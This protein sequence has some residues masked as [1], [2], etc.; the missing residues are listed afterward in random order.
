MSLTM[1]IA[2]G[3]QSLQDCVHRWATQAVAVAANTFASMPR[4]SFPLHAIVCPAPAF[5]VVQ[6]RRF[7]NT[8]AGAQKVFDPDRAQAGG[9]YHFPVRCANNVI[10]LTACHVVCIIFHSG[11]STTQGR[12]RC[13]LHFPVAGQWR[14]WVTDDNTAAV[15]PTEE[16]W[17]NVECTSYLLWLRRV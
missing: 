3:E 6:L 9:V 5:L 16:Q 1:D 17:K 15:M 8:T 7:A 4:E 14:S 11:T 2:P 12:Y 10:T 13:L